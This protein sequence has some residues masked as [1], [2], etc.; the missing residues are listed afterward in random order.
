MG[1]RRTQRSGTNLTA[2]DIDTERAINA[3]KR[4]EAM[5]SHLHRVKVCLLY[6][7]IAAIPLIYLILLFSNW[8]DLPTRTNILNMGLSAVIS[9]TFGRARF[10]M[11]STD[12]D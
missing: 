7:A 1:H 12:D 2:A 6:A 3:H 5:K 11:N 9:Y 8:A 10:N 4:R